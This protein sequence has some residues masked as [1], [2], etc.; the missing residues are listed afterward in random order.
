MRK[1]LLSA[2]AVAAF[3]LSIGTAV[4]ADQLDD[5]SLDQV[6]AGVG[7]NGPAFTTPTSINLGAYTLVYDGSTWTRVAN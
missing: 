3:A 4:A 1:S 2:I 5:G 6:T 7:F